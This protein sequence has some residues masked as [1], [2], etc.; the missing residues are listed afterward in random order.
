MK[1]KKR[2]KRLQEKQLWYDRQDK[3]YQAAH[4]R[5]GSNKKS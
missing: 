4:K 5:A 3:N 1:A 2:L